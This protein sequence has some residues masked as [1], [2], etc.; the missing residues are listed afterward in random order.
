MKTI[1]QVIIEVGFSRGMISMLAVFEPGHLRLTM[2]MLPAELGDNASLKFFL[3]D[4][5]MHGSLPDPEGLDDYLR[6]LD[7]LRGDR[8][9]EWVC[10]PSGIESQAVLEEL[11]RHALQRDGHVRVGVGDCPLAAEGRTNSD[12]VAEVVAMAR[13]TGR[14]PASVEDAL[15]LLTAGAGVARSA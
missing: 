9:I 12:L 7:R 14:K 13:D 1:K 10:A 5:W 3:S 11:L 6:M 4:R 8:Q 15:R 2:S